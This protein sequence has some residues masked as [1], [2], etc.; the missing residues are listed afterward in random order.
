MILTITRV[1]SLKTTLRQNTQTRKQALILTSKT[2]ANDL[3]LYSNIE[4]EQSKVMVRE[5]RKTNF[6]ELSLKA[7]TGE[8]FVKKVLR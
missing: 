3:A 1:Y 5:M 7:L 8:K 2:F 6:Y 4:R